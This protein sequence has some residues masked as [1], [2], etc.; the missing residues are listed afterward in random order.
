MLQEL[1]L[2][3]K[4][5]A[6]LL[7]MERKKE[8]H[9]N[10]D[11]KRSRHHKEESKPI[12]TDLFQSHLDKPQ[13]QRGRPKKKPH[14]EPSRD[15]VVKESKEEVEE[16]VE[17]IPMEIEPE[18]DRHS[19]QKQVMDTPK[20]LQF[21]LDNTLYR[22]LSG[23]RELDLDLFQEQIAKKLAYLEPMIYDL[24]MK[25]HATLPK[26]VNEEPIHQYFVQEVISSSILKTRCFVV[27]PL[28][29]CLPNGLNSFE[30]LS[31]PFVN[32]QTSFSLQ[33][34]R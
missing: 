12:G 32:T 28:L 6:E 11:H 4:Q 31:N 24:R 22:N 9:I 34:R 7:K 20:I 3:Y 16:E 26:H 30:D 8:K 14:I 15:Y 29:V 18:S 33:R 19:P 2:L 25:L 23:S 27:L 13:R 5:Q 21:S 10:D 1:H 17:T